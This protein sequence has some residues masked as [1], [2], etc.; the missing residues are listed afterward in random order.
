MLLKPMKRIVLFLIFFINFTSWSFSFYAKDTI[1]TPK[2]ITN[3]KQLFK[4]KTIDSIVTQQKNT[5]VKINPTLKKDSVLNVIKNSVP[6][7]WTFKNEP[8]IILTQTSFLNWVKGGN[9]TVAGIASFKGNYNFKKGQLFWKN[10]VLIKY[11]LARENGAENSQKTEDIIDLKSSVGYKTTV[12]SKWYY[13]GEYSLTTQFAN[14]YRGNDRTNIISTFFAP[15]RMRLGVGAV[16][17]DEEDNFKIHLSPLTNQVTFVLNKELSEQGAFGVEKGE[18]FNAELG[19]LIEVEYK[20]VLM[21]NINFSLKSSFY[22]D[23]I[24]QFGNIDSDIKIN[25]DMKVNNYIKSNINSHLIYDDDT[26]I[27]QDDGTQL[28]PRVQL[29]QILGVG[30]TYTF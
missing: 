27:A 14:G 30:V 5:V 4:E 23:Y 15:A 16:Y 29:K 8:G 26:R 19:T 17:T 13:S 9:N 25:I 10:G 6:K 7:Y 24:N 20:T 28:G 1:P 2:V 12:T 3:L 11:G 22:S 21:K 18:K